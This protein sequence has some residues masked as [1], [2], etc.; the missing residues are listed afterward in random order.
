[1]GEHL[2]LTDATVSESESV[3]EQLSLASFIG[4]IRPRGEWVDSLVGAEG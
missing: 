3:Y 2:A 1:M 4:L